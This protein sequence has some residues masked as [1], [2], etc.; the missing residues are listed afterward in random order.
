[1]EP[2]LEYLDQLS[3]RLAHRWRRTFPGMHSMGEISRPVYQMLPDSSDSV[4]AGRRTVVNLIPDQ[5]RLV[6][7]CLTTG[8][9]ISVAVQNPHEPGRTWNSEQ[10]VALTGVCE[11]DIKE[12]LTLA[13]QTAERGI[14]R[15][16]GTLC[17]EVVTF[18]QVAPTVKLYAAYLGLHLEF[19]LTEGSVPLKSIQFLAQEG[20][21]RWESDRAPRDREL[22][23]FVR[24]RQP[25][26]CIHLVRLHHM[27]SSYDGGNSGMTFVDVGMVSAQPVFN[28]EGPLLPE[29]EPKSTFGGSLSGVLIPRSAISDQMAHLAVIAFNLATKEHERS[30]V[31]AQ[32]FS[33]YMTALTQGRT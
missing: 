10:P 5:A 25:H 21:L 19:E 14:G 2:T 4:A 6:L 16:W 32:A 11:T 31:L 18:S 13:K 1:M 20:T 27:P 26:P 12:I 3:D 33:L 22:C 7:D 15:T 24:A 17:A 9:T 8:V 29:V 30:E 28:S 23:W